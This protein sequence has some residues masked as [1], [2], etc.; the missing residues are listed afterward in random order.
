MPRWFLGSLGGRPWPALKLRGGELLGRLE[1]LVN[2]GVPI[3]PMITVLTGITESMVLP[4]PRIAEILPPFL[5]FA[6]DAVIVGH[7]IRSDC[8]FLDAALV[9]S[10][11]EARRLAAQKG[12]AMNDQPVTSVD[13]R[14]TPSDGWLLR[15]GNHRVVRVKLR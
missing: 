9:T 13:E 11:S 14:V 4:A 6:R 1:S 5:E 8:A 2:P 3:P 10:K 12:L 15:R 7:N